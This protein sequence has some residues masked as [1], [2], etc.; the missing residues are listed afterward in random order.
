[1]SPHTQGTNFI[2]AV[3]HLGLCFDQVCIISRL[4]RAHALDLVLG[5]G[6]RC[7]IGVYMKN[8]LLNPQHHPIKILL[9]SK[10]PSIE[11]IPHRRGFDSCTKLCKY[12]TIIITCIYCKSK[13][14]VI[15]P[16]QLVDD[17]LVV[18]VL[19]L[20]L[21][22]SPPHT[23]NNTY[24]YIF[25]RSWVNM[26]HTYRKPTSTSAPRCSGSVSISSGFW[27]RTCPRLIQMFG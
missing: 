10:E 25:F 21:V 1:M 20:Q 16:G 8:S 12:K 5:T 13:Q 3:S 22:A 19:V 14:E 23:Y 4:S 15:T 27:K 11:A 18:V 6:G 26:M 9:A 7:P 24:I 2:N 17:H